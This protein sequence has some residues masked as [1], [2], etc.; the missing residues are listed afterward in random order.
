MQIAG[1]ALFAVLLRANLPVEAAS[2]LV[3]NPLTSRCSRWW[4]E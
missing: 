1:A 3:S 2:T 4:A